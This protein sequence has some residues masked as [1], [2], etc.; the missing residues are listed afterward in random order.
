MTR[1]AAASG[2]Q[3]DSTLLVVDDEELVRRTV[4]EAHRDERSQV[5]EAAT[6][7]E[8]LAI[9]AK[10]RVDL[11]LLAMDL[12]E[13]GESGIDVLRRISAQW[14]ETLVIMMAAR[15]G[16]K[17][18]GEAV[19]TDCYQY[20]AKP[21]DVDQLRLLIRNALASLEL[22]REVE[23]LRLDQ[24]PWRDGWVVAESGC[25]SDVFANVEKIARSG[26]STILIEGETG[27]GK[28]IIARCIHGS[29]GRPRGS[30]VNINCAWM[31]GPILE[32]ALFGLARG[33]FNEVYGDGRGLIELAGRGTV[34][35]ESISEMPLNLQSKLLQVLDSRTVR[36]GGGT[37]ES[38][39]RCLFVVATNRDLEEEVRAGRLREDLKHRIS[40]A[41]IVIPPLR[42]RR[43]DI[44]I[45]AKQLFDRFNR[46]L[47][48]EVPGIAPDA[49]ELLGCYG[50]PGNMRELKNVM[51]RLVLT[52]R[53]GE[54]RPE[55]LPPEIRGASGSIP[56]AGQ[57]E[58]TFPTG[59]VLKLA[60]VEQAAVAHAL[61]CFRGNQVMAAEELGV[62]RQTLRRKLRAHPLK[63]S[64]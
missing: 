7:A 47:S 5:L 52:N 58:I 17:S 2:Q 60:D 4:S 59:R 42:N 61:A 33:S 26:C 46:E 16:D 53:G 63:E 21:I 3:F 32:G 10:T 64:Q 27:V 1:D 18:V 50:W 56:E 14:P 45:L 20:I 35:L 43:E 15:G 57:E 11:V 55:H 48:R 6:G 30:F 49:L 9:L 44:P 34:Y 41:S 24:G 36:P 25:M 28:K 8:A 12:S 51:E 39:V 54:V 19:Q 62:S 13:S 29:T 40:M 37:T 38:T 22:K 23:V 31:P